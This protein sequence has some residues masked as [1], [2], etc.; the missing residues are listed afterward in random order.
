MVLEEGGGVQIKSFRL[1]RR[2]V[3]WLGCCYFLVISVNKMMG[4]NLASNSSEDI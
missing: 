4:I 3:K 1:F 2:K